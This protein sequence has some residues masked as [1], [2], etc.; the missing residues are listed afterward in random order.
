MHV[1]IIT[2]S[3]GGAESLVASL[4]EVGHSVTLAPGSPDV[5][6]H[7]RE[8]PL[9]AII[10]DS[11]SGAAADDFRHRVQAMRPACRILFVSNLETPQGRGRVVSPR[12][13]EIGVSER[14]LA[15]LFAETAGTA[16]PSDGGAKVQALIQALDVVVSLLESDDP[17]FAGFSHRVAELSH[18]VARR[19]GLDPTAREEIEIASLLH[20]VGKMA[21]ES[22]ILRHAGTLAGPEALRM[23][24]HVPWGE[25]LIAHIEFPWR[26][27]DIV[28]HHHER[29]DGSGYPGGLQGRQ[30][31]IGARIIAAV[32]AYVAMVSHRRHR[33]AL[34]D[35]EARGELTRSS[36]TQLDPEVVEVLLRVVLERAT[37]SKGVRARV[38]IIDPDA[39]FERLLR[40]R[41]TTEGLDADGRPSIDD[42]EP[43]LRTQEMSLLLVDAASGGVAAIEAARAAAVAAGQPDVPLAVLADQ[44]DRGLRRE[45]LRLGVEDY[46]SKAD[47]LEDIVSRIKNV[48]VRERRRSTPPRAA[49]EEGLVGSLDTVDL[50]EIL[51]F[52]ALG[53]KSARVVLTTSDGEGDVWLSSGNIVHATCGTQTG[54]SALNVM[55]GWSAGRFRINHGVAAPQR[56]IQ[57][58]TMSVLLEGLRIRDEAQKTT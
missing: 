5:A 58:D 4:R 18:E 16:P 37:E 53:Q 25:R 8:I 33:P 21:L 26:V 7:I 11:V 13:G 23:R 41:L 45:C 30:I 51:Q 52:L 17:Y 54:E 35:E 14:D 38:A 28:R 22:S 44:D 40:L 50:P 43:L 46:I 27:L 12:P 48:L 9:G 1:L 39:Q 56:T 47:D 20:D 31:P 24:E 2:K 49:T 32:D 19:L 10:V 42:V 36:G 55:L 15:A 29:Y 57:G 6:R 34:R 3:G